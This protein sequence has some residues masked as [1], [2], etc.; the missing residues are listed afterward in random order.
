MEKKNL[1]LGLFIYA[2]RY[3]LTLSGYC[4]SYEP[5]AAVNETGAQCKKHGETNK[6]ASAD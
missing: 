5:Q 3:Q 4:N 2:C 6:G 1:F